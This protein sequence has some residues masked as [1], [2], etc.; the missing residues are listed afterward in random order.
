MTHE[1]N[2]NNLKTAVKGR[3][4]RNS[5]VELF[6][7]DYKLV[8]K[9][10]GVGEDITAPESGHEDYSDGNVYI[11]TATLDIWKLEG[12]A[13]AKKGNLK[14]IKSITT[15][16]SAVDEGYNEV[17]ITTT[18][19]EVTTFRVKNGSKGPSGNGIAE[20]TSSRDGAVATYTLHFTDGDEFS[21]SVVDGT[22]ATWGELSDKP[23]NTI[24]ADFIVEDNELMLSEDVKEI[25]EDV[26]N[27]ANAADIINPDDSDKWEDNPSRPWTK[28]EV[29]I[30]ANAA[31]ECLVN[32]S[33][34][35]PSTDDGTHW[36]KLTL[37]ALKNI[38]EI[39][40]NKLDPLTTRTFATATEWKDSLLA[41]NTNKQFLG[42]TV[43]VVKRGNVCIANILIGFKNGIVRGY[44]APSPYV[45]D[46]L[47]KMP[48]APD[49][50]VRYSGMFYSGSSWQNAVFIFS[51][52]G[53][54]YFSGTGLTFNNGVTT[55]SPDGCTYFQFTLPYY[56]K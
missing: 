25:L 27:K 38:A 5:M 15:T 52:D 49:T 11:N 46:K 55:T 40:N 12:N 18:D 33:N 28:G 31:W 51:T 35:R 50:E 30:E 45:P 14:G 22:G 1:Q 2:I 23:F 24:G 44:H 47:F 34:T 8:K 56:T 7:E 42:R 19:D 43:N 4:V 37:T 16:E 26:S 13:W 54:V 20:V 29:C 32:N 10:I 36:K 6:E 17:T 53:Y 9:G 21:F 39:T 41:Q 3:D 48:F